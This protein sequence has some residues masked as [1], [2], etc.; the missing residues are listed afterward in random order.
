MF[1]QRLANAAQARTGV[2]IFHCTIKDAGGAV[3]QQ[4][5]LDAVELRA[6]HI[7]LFQCS[8]RR[9]QT[10]EFGLRVGASSKTALAV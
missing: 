3:A 4:H 2:E 9:Q 6:W 7:G 8:N 5:P 10:G 1:D